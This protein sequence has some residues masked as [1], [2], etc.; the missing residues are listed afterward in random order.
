[1]KRW[2]CLVLCVLLL[3]ACANGVPDTPKTT[4]GVT[5][6]TV[7]TVV[8]VS[9]TDTT[10]DIPTTAT[11]VTTTT[12]SKVITSTQSSRTKK[13]YSYW[14]SWFDTEWYSFRLFISSDSLPSETIIYEDGRSFP[15]EKIPELIDNGTV[16]PEQTY[17][18]VEQLRIYPR[19]FNSSEILDDGEMVRL[20]ED[21]A[22]T[23]V[24][25]E[26]RKRIYP[27]YDFM[28]KFQIRPSS[29]EGDYEYRFYFNVAQLQQLMTE[30]GVDITIRDDEEWLTIGDTKFI[31]QSAAEAC[32]VGVTV[33]C[34]GGEW[35][36]EVIITLP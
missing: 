24:Q 18:V 5:T 30:A 33:N 19:Y 35:V 25:G 4:D 14:E 12:T 6:P 13:Y 34:S 20:R 15:Q 27:P 10:A 29:A 21:V 31:S 11:T 17:E 22:V 28:G 8:T 2:L 23:V 9:T 32:G 36:K 16:T 1:M 26:K 3:T 7:E